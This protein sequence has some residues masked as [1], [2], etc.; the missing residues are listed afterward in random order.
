MDKQG[1]DK[2]LKALRIAREGERKMKTIFGK[3]E[4]KE[5]TKM[6]RS[7]FENSKTKIQGVHYSRYI[8]SWNNAGG[9]D[10][11]GEQFKNWLKANDCTEDE[12][13][14]ICFIAENGKMELE[15]TAKKFIKKMNEA[16][17][18]IEN[19]EEPEEEP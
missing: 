10:Y 15:L 13:N 9:A 19:N 4:I 7:D 6:V 18:K 8:A 5:E 11:Y 2:I 12:I 14:D 3:K 17:E 16:F 1:F